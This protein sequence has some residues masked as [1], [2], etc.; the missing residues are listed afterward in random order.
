MIG[1]ALPFS[2]RSFAEQVINE[3]PEDGRTP[4]ATALDAFIGID[5][6]G[7]VFFTVPKIEMGQARRAAWR[8]S[9][10]RSWRWASSRSP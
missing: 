1:F 5:R 6:Q 4:T 7:R 9:S 2:G 3:G 10:P 8:R